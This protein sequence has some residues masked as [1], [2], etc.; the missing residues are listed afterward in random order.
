MT[1]KQIAKQA[2]V[3]A[4]TVSHVINGSAPV[5]EETRKKVLKIIQ[6]SGYQSNI[7]AKGLRGGKTKMIGVL[8]EDISVWHTA[9]IIDGINA[10]ADQHRYNIIL[11]NLRLNS[12][13]GNKFSEIMSYKDDIDRAV[14]TLLAMQVD[15]IIYIGMHDREI[16]HVLNHVSKPIVYCYCYT[17][18]GEGSSVRYDNEKCIYSLTKELIEDGHQRIGIIRGREDSEPSQIRTKGFQRALAAYG[19]EL[20]ESWNEVGDW[21]YQGGRD[22]AIRM[23]TY[24]DKKNHRCLRSS[25]ERPSAIVALND[26]MAIGVYNAAAELGLSIPGDLSVTGFDNSELSQHI[27]PMLTTISRP[28]CEMGGRALELLR[29]EINHDG[30]MPVTSVVF[31][32]QIF[33]RGSIRKLS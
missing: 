7:L 19:M 23:L 22:A 12:K 30:T 27:T 24:V 9:Q 20:Q 13:T 15:G 3:T 28:L 1:L 11:S 29:T 4:A 18:D 6:E 5:S 16:S 17:N 31:P 21:T 10:V 14:G 26:E 8:V 2:G 32:C 25:L 33:K